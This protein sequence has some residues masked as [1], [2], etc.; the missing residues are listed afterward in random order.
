MSS[1]S[2]QAVP[3]KKKIYL[4]RKYWR[5]PLSKRRIYVLR[6]YWAAPVKEKNLCPQKMLKYCQG[7]K[8][9]FSENTGAAPVKKKNLCPRRRIIYFL[10]KY[11]S[12]PLRVNVQV[13]SRCERSLCFK[14]KELKNVE[15]QLEGVGG[16]GVI[17]GMG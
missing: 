8:S 14:F 3:V 1:E 9:M 7:E 17:K 12:S 16:I 13:L 2:T 4:F 15:R 10:R 5:S 6:K 11:W